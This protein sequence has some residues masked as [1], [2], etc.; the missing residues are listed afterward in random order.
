MN[1]RAE[2]MWRHNQERGYGS[3]LA[4]APAPTTVLGKLAVTFAVDTEGPG[5]RLRKQELGGASCWADLTWAVRRLR[6][7]GRRGTG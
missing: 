1:T 6:L 4:L 3:F 7:V 2:R 5:L